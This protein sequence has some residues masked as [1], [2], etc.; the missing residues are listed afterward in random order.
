MNAV[1]PGFLERRFAL[2]ARRTSVRIEILA[3]I[4]T[5]LAAAYLLVVIP[6]LLATGGMDRGAA[7]TSVILVFVASSVLMGFYANLP[8][9]VGP[10]IG[11]SVILGVTMAFK[12]GRGT[13][14]LTSLF[15]GALIPLILIIVFAHKL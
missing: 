14:A 13:L 8:F 6:S 4:T 11:G 2:A 10:G 7:T 9:I 12:F 5:F 15:A 1:S 3:G